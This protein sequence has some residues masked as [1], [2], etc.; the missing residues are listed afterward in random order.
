MGRLPVDV[1]ARLR[2]RV[3]RGQQGFWEVIR[4]LKTFT[5]K[6]IDQRCGGARQTVRDFVKRLERAGYVEAEDTDAATGAIRY[7]LL[8]DQP[9]APQLRRDGSPARQRLGQE[10]MWRVMRMSGTGGFTAAD[11]ALTAST[12]EHPVPLTAAQSYLKALKRAGYLMVVQPGKP[13]H[14]PGTGSLTV[15]RLIPSMKT[16][17][18]APQVQRIKAVWDPNLRR[19]VGDA[20]VEG[21]SS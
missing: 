10:Q 19:H 5:V 8:I 6:D 20:E 3:P 4:D 11:L 14:R 2:V 18:L 15:Y 21:V 16:G 13:G 17:P 1:Q 9:D 12:E 7:R